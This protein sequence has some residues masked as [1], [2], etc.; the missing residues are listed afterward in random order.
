MHNRK[1]WVRVGLVMV[2]LAALGTL[3]AQAQALQFQWGTS[4]AS[5]KPADAYGVYDGAQNC[6]VPLAQGDFAELIW[7]GPDGQINPPKADGSTTGDDLRVS[8]AAANSVDYNPNNTLPPFLLGKGYIPFKWSDVEV[9]V[10]TPPNCGSVYIRAWNAA[11]PQAASYYGDSE[12]FGGVDPNNSKQCSFRYGSWYNWPR[13]CANKF[14]PPLG[15]EVAYFTATARPAGVLL[16]WE[17][18]TESEL[19]GFD[20]QRG[21]AKSGPWQKLNA[22]PIP[23]AN[24]GGGSHTYTWT[25]TTAVRGKQYFYR[26]D[27]HMTAGGT[28]VLADTSVS[29]GV[30]DKRVWLPLLQR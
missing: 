6:T 5:G 9:S 19:L 4:Y 13:W 22:L 15:A 10:G 12:L 2:T 28:A 29:Y 26:L 27:G 21:P 7:A 23:T 20:L 24:P 25:D 1:R 11:T 16:A 14:I 30:G 8:A 3:V 17:T 18:V